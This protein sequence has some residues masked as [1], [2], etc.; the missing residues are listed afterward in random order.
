M[1]KPRTAGL[2]ATWAMFFVCLTSF[3]AEPSGPS[4][5]LGTAER[6]VKASSFGFDEADATRALQAAIDSGAAKV[7][8]DNVGK[9]WIVD[10]IALAS[11][12][13][14]FFEKGVEVIAKK[15]GFKGT[16]DSLFRAH[17]RKNV[18]LTGYGATLRMRRGDYAGPDYQKAEWR[19]VLDLR[20]CEHVRIRGLTLAESGGDGI[21]LGT[22][23]AGVANKDIQIQ[24][25]V[26]EKNYRQG[27]SVINAEDLL[28][29]DCVLRD[30]A[31][32]PP[33]AGIDFEPNRP[34]ERLVN[35]TVRRC[36][37][38]NNAG[39]GFLVSVLP[40]N[41]ASAPVS[42][43][44]EN[45]RSVGDG[46]HAVAIYTGNLPDKAVRGTIEF[47]DCRFEA[48]KN[49]G[50]LVGNK[51]AA[52]C[53]L[54]F[55]RCALLDVAAANEHGAPIVFMADANAGEPLGG[56]A[57]E[58]CTIRDRMQR[59]PIL[60]H[61]VTGGIGLIDLSGRLTLQTG[62]ES[63]TVTITEKQ[64]AEWVPATAIRAIPR[65]PLANVAIKPPVAKSKEKTASLDFAR[66]RQ[67]ARLALYAAQGDE[68]VLRVR[69]AQVAQYGGSDATLKIISPSG[70]QIH[71]ER[72]PFQGESDVH[73]RVP[74]SGLYRLT[75]DVG[76]N[77]LQIVSASHAVYLD[78]EA[79]PIHLMS[80]PGEFFFWVPAGTRRFG[81]RVFGEGLGEGV[82]A[83]LIDP[84]GQVVEQGDDIAQLR[85][86]EV[87]CP[88]GC[89]G[90]VWSVRLARPSRLCLED[91]Y[92]DLRGVPP[93][94]A[95][96]RDAVLRIDP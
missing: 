84:R 9:P 19:H 7:I 93:L 39:G 8:V 15:G 45:C 49:A 26:C 25:V 24:D 69:H 95:A 3:G 4:A 70:S 74:A 62:D 30:T 22:A 81:V 20:S 89:A 5:A 13:E 94:L 50:V 61:D 33:Q 1:W 57:F 41:A 11:N 29:E 73:F 72:L 43:R 40:L 36:A 54:R 71:Q 83:S 92:I 2:L 31:G 48:S 60:L 86:F 16:T 52:A 44:F 82:K 78:G 37:S 79:G 42:L 65:L 17:L 14:V 27:I 76:L 23:K 87:N 90:E 63:K 59:K 85:Q 21:Y 51:P 28:I 46:P 91:H 18:T 88:D 47:T 6:V 96:S 67:T 34:D 56:V 58:D 32:T 53:R 10:P 64:L 77:C 55:V 80:S 12:Q 35:C 38:E 75:A 66:L 68:V